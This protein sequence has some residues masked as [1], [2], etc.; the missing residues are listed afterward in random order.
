MCSKS[1]TYVTHLTLAEPLSDEFREGEEPPKVPLLETDRTG[2][3]PSHLS[4]EAAEQLRS[5]GALNCTF[6]LL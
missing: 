3:E 4:L 1:I 6:F 2:Q 5:P